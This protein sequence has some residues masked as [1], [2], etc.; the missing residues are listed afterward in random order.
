LKY[1]A[2]NILLAACLNKL[3][4][5]K[6]LLTF[7][8]TI[9]FTTG[10]IS[11][12]TAYHAGVTK[13]SRYE[14]Y[15]V[16]LPN[17]H[18]LE[19]INNGPNYPWTVF[20]G[21]TLKNRYLINLDYSYG[22]YHTGFIFKHPRS[23]YGGASVSVEQSHTISLIGGYYI[24]P[25][26][27]RFNIIP[28]AGIAFANSGYYYGSFGIKSSWANPNKDGTWTIRQCTSEWK[29]DYGMHKFHLF[30]KADMK[31]TYSPFEFLTLFLQAG[32]NQGFH[33]I[34]DYVGWVQV[35][36]EPVIE[37]RNRS[38]GSYTFLAIGLQVDIKMNNDE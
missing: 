15:E 4:M 36:D 20:V 19:K 22:Y 33:K 26:H 21:V 34:G 1:L 16:L 27:S 23:D 18:I 32:Y 25:A 13:Q 17:Q 35:A 10:L 31:F 30:A 24:F 38:R 9:T 29:T 14:I 8:F 12:I 7:L 2:A 37:I 28:S 6:F 5:N 11:Q 3:I